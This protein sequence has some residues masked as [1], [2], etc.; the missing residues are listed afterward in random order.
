M[1]VQ[2]LRMLSKRYEVGLLYFEKNNESAPASCAQIAKELNISFVEPLYFPNI[3]EIILNLITRFNKSLQESL[4]YSKDTTKKINKAIST[5]KPELIVADMIRSGQFVEDT[6]IPKILEMDDLLSERYERFSLNISADDNLLGTFSSILPKNIA[7]LLNLYFKPAVLRYEAKKIRR[8]EVDAVNNFD[9]ITLV[10]ILEAQK[11]RSVTG[12][13][14]IFSIPP[15]VDR[16]YPRQTAHRT[17]TCNILFFGNLITNQNLSSIRYIIEK[18][19]P[20]LDLNGFDYHFSIAG[21]YDSRAERLVEKNPNT[22]LLGFVSSVEDLFMSHDVFL[23]PIS[24]GSGIKTKILDAMAHGLP[25]ITNDIGI[26]GIPAIN[27]KECIVANE[28]ETIAKALITLWDDNSIM[29]ELSENAKNLIVRHFLFENVEH[30][31]ISIL[32]NLEKV[33]DC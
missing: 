27:G 20:V 33:R 5:F 26:E 24:F 14:N 7:N 28:P 2:S 32:S 19:L 1:I 22:D 23:S 4:F 10:S 11:L 31:F 6:K 21:S 3:P 18:V 16:I 29:W 12:G 17:C 15:T 30:D 25:V 8:W 13:V 9:V